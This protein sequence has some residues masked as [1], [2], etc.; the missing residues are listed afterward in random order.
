MIDPEFGHWLAGFT[1][2]EGC[3]TARRQ[4]HTDRSWL[5]QFT[6]GLR[7]DDRPILETIQAELGVGTLRDRPP[8]KGPIGGKPQTIW[9]TSS[10]EG[11][12]IV[13]DVFR[14]YP[15]RSKKARDFHFWSLAVDLWLAQRPT[16]RLDEAFSIQMNV[17]ATALREGRRFVAP[18]TE[19][20]IEVVPDLPPTLF[21]GEMELQPG[22][23]DA[24]MEVQR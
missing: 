20:A 2:G 16:W 1:D 8:G 13:R 12:G 9:Q 22:K 19:S 7:Q 18:S 11:C 21:E 4:G 3:F 5:C 6:I 14:A 15:L 23:L 17:Y 24:L 10:K